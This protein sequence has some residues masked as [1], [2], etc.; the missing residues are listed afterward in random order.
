M[1]TR[2]PGLTLNY[3]VR[4]HAGDEFFEHDGGFQIR[5]APK[6]LITPDG[7]LRETRRT[8]TVPADSIAEQTRATRW[9]PRVRL[10][11]AEIIDKDK[12]DKQR[13]AAEHGLHVPNS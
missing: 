8:S 1:K 11:V 3:T 13:L 4:M 9:E 12:A 6:T 2:T 5:F 10:T 7:R